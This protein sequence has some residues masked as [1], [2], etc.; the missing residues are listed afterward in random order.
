MNSL[1][2]H[3]LGAHLI[4]MT[5]YLRYVFNDFF[6]IA[7]MFCFGGLAYE[8]SMALKHLPKGLWW[9]QPLVLLVMF[10]SVQLGGF[11]D[12]I[13]KADY[14][15]L[16]PK[17]QSFYKY[18]KSAMRYSYLMASIIQ[19]LLWIIL[20]P[21]VA[22]TFSKFSGIYAAFMLIILLLN[23]Y[24][25]MNVSFINIYRQ[26][27]EKRNFIFKIVIPILTFYML[28][29]ISGIISLIVSILIAFYLVFVKNN[30][31]NM[32][33]NWNKVIENENS[34]M[35][36]IYQ[37]FNMFTE[38]PMLEGKVK[39]RKYLDPLLSLFNNN[40]VFAYL[41]VRGIFRDKEV[42]GLYIRLTLIG[43]ILI[44][45]INNSILAILLS[46]LFIYLIVFQI[47]PYYSN[48]DDNAFTYIYPISDENKLAS[49]TSIIN[50]LMILTILLFFVATIFSNNIMTSLILIVLDTIELY[51]LTKFYINKKVNKAKLKI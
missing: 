46:L 16:M 32:S 23:K 42:S 38:V 17:E 41:Y 34:R 33:I 3:R 25:I 1:F 5:K 12:F 19:I 35:H 7:L 28:I 51:L 50:R 4:E 47:I 29:W 36:R 8:Y 44:L 45:F 31:S 49:F 22:V 6:V 9:S 14:V 21:F 18:F 20:L 40:N 27:S 2:K 26:D 39:R 30:C 24:I 43:T 15:F 48:F 37:F 11:A 10:I 13:K